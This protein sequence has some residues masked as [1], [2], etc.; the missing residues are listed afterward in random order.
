MRT[1]G[2]LI[3]SLQQFD[4][5]A[6]ILAA[7]QPGWPLQ[8]VISDVVLHEDNECAECGG[9]DGHF[10]GCGSVLKERSAGP[11]YIVLGGSPSEPLSPY[12]PRSVFD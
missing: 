6:V 11:V 9:E 3:E 12:A 10:T 2:D 1:V 8:E 7:H 5:D 4:A